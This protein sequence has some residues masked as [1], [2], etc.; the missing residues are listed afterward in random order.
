MTWKNEKRLRAETENSSKASL[1]NNISN[2]IMQHGVSPRKR[3]A[4]YDTI[5][6]YFEQDQATI[7][8]SRCEMKNSATTLHCRNENIIQFLSAI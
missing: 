7:N 4:E 1:D 2:W 3:W 8:L 5:L 6:S